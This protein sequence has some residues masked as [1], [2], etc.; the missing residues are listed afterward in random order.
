MLVTNKMVQEAF[1]YLTDGASKAA[2]ARASRVRAEY[3]LKQ[4]KARL[5]LDVQGAIA[6]REAMA[7]VHEDYEEALKKMVLAI[8]QDEYHRNAKDTAIAIIEAWRTEQA[9]HRNAG[10][11]G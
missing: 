4:T 8:E 10:R 1:D 6:L 5:M 2:S 11:V 7:E 9:N 3:R